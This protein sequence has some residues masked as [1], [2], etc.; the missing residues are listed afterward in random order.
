MRELKEDTAFLKQ[1]Q[2]IIKSIY[3]ENTEVLKVKIS[4]VVVL[5]KLQKFPEGGKKEKAWKWER[6]DKKIRRSVQEVQYANNRN[7]AT[8]KE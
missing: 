6:K 7:S 5:G 8:R 3:S 1:K 2:Q 4:S